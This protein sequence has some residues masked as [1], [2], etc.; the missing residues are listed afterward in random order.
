M[1]RYLTYIISGAM[2]LSVA[3]WGVAPVLGQQAPAQSAAQNEYIGEF[4]GWKV[5][6]SKGN[7][8]FVKKTIS[9]FGTRWGAEPQTEQEFED[10]TWEQL[11]LSFEAYCRGI[12]VEQKELDTEI[13][14]MLTAE[15]VTFDRAKDHAAYEQWVKD[16]AKE[17]VEVFENQLRH[18]IQLEKLRQQA[19]D[20]FKVTVT[21]Q[22]ARQE[23]RNEYNTLEL[24]LVQFDELD[25]AKEY[26]G[27][28]RDYALWDAE[29]KKDPKF[30]RRPGFV[31]LEFLLNM[32]KIPKD[33]LYKMMDL[34]V[35][36]IYPPTPVWKGYGVFR[37]VKKRV[38]DE[39]EFPKLRDSYF[40]Q[41]EM[42]KKYEQLGV[43]L[44]NLKQEA[45]II[46]YPAAP[47]AA[48]KK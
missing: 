7:Y 2:F 28:M 38:A 1:R 12:S 21:E 15:K 31:S 20:S 24:E 37:I 13:S 29:G 3:G 26:Y 43:W 45:G 23:F 10:R 8:Y 25:K 9:V 5:P 4:S 39:Q 34:D 14:K 17:P 35:N 32:W 6:V 30:C 36:S 42:N 41:V 40:K 16:K 22:E 33:D 46:V 11:V 44:K 27:K 18:L 19:L 48:G 47:A